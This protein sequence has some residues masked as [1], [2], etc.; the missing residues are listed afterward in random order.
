MQYG[1]SRSVSPIKDAWGPA[2]LFL[3]WGSVTVFTFFFIM[4]LLPET[5]GYS[6]EE[7]ES[8][9][10]NKPWYRVGLASW[11]P[12]KGQATNKYDATPLA[13]GNKN[14]GS[15]NGSFKGDIDGAISPK[16]LEKGE[17]QTTYQTK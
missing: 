14:D 17:P 5:S 9:L 2:G 12:K 13:Y 1:S 7:M 6:L 11:R 3:F 10:F 15:D 4:F 8:E 16:T